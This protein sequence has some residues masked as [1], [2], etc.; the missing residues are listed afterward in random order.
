M[1]RLLRPALAGALLFCTIPVLA[2]SAADELVPHA[3]L[4]ARLFT[5]APP[6]EG[7][8]KGLARVLEALEPS[9][10]TALPLTPSQITQ[11]ISS[12]LDAGKNQE[13]LEIINRRQAQR[14]AAGELGTDVQLLFLKGR[15]LSALGEHNDA[16][17]L[18]QGMTE[19]FPELP[20]PWNNLA[21]EYVRQGKFDLAHDA[22]Q[23]ALGIN[24]KFA[25]AQNN[26]GKVLLLQAHAAY[27]QA[28]RLGAAGAANQA[29]RIAPI[30]TN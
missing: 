8:W 28:A 23:M 30:L 22:L 20:E 10:D 24:P 15:A 2:D 29:A 14:D 6:T 13:A 12:M 18:Y 17:K 7:G 11:R 27:T 5:D 16:I 3:D 9:I 26:L 1:H 19:Q 21:A 25:L 4:N